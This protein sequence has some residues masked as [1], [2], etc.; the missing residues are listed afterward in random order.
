MTTITLT[1][2]ISKLLSANDRGTSWQAKAAKTKWIRNAAHCITIAEHGGKP[3]LGR[4]HLTVYIAA[5][6]NRRRDA[7]NLSPTIKAGLD[8]IVSG[9][10][11]VDDSDA[12]LVGPDPRPDTERS[13]RGTYRFTF[14]F[15]E[16][17]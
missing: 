9:G 16:I 12:H 3:P 5:P 13:E 8:G 17:S 4:V 2:P 11:L 6:T 10:L 14:V 7:A 1:V 15:Q